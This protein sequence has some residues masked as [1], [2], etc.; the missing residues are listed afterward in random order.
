M[1]AVEL[2]EVVISKAQLHR[3]RTS[4]LRPVEIGR[5]LFDAAPTSHKIFY[6]LAGY[7]HN[8]NPPVSFYQNL[9][10]FLAGNPSGGE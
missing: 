2:E 9:V 8:D 6:E 5:Q 1:S 3:I 7:G 10:K 4:D